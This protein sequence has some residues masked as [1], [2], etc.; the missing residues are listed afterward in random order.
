MAMVNAGQSLFYKIAGVSG[1]IAVAIGAYESHGKRKQS[2]PFK[3][4]EKYRFLDWKWKLEIAAKNLFDKIESS[5]GSLVG[6]CC[7]FIV[8][9]LIFFAL[10][11]RTVLYSYKYLFQLHHSINP[12]Q[13]N[14]KRYL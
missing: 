11:R 7:K 1:L 3:R 6:V 13:L 10:F 8:S 4:N 12:K 5:R 14:I 2:P 9:D